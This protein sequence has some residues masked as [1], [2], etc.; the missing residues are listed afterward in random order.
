MILLTL[1]VISWVG[2]SSTPATGTEMVEATANPTMGPPDNQTPTAGVDNTVT[3]DLPLPASAE[4]PVLLCDHFDD[5]H[6]NWIIE[7]QDNPY[8][9]YNIDIRDGEYALDFTSKGF[10]NY[11]KNALTWFNVASAKDFALSVTTLMNSD[12]KNCSWGAAFRGDEDSFFLFSIYNDGTYAFEIYENKAWTPLITKRTFDGIK[13]G[14]ENTLAITAQGEIFNFSIN[15]IPF[16]EYQGGLL[17]GSDILL[18]VSAK[19]G[20]RAQYYFDNLV[21]QNLQ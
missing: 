13:L 3:C 6:N 20:V 21:L 1:I 16:I 14:K 9:K 7:S 8:A 19:E 5:N 10:A 18:V 12:F 4:Y 2:C 15:G 17:Q 11:Q